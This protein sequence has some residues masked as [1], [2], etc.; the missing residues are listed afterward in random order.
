MLWWIHIK[1]HCKTSKV[2]ITNQSSRRAFGARLIEALG[3]SVSVQRVINS[4]LIIDESFLYRADHL[5][6]F[7]FD[8][9]LVS[10]H[11]HSFVCIVSFLVLCRWRSGFV[12]FPYGSTPAWA[13]EFCLSVGDGFS[14]LWRGQ[15]SFDLSCLATPDSTWSPSQ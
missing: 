12:V 2:N 3:A 11:K 6:F 10:C 1:C 8:G 13:T 9:F 14:F 7:C 5:I 15:F 4:N